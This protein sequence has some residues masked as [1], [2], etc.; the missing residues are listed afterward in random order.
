MFNNI[1]LSFVCEPTQSVACGNALTFGCVVRYISY[2]FI[3]HTVIFCHIQFVFFC[4]IRSSLAR[5][6]KSGID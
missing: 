5:R 1:K 2:L 6:L 3:H 4:F